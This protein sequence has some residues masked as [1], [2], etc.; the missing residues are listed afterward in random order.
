[1]ARKFSFFNILKKL[2]IVKIAYFSGYQILTNFIPVFY[3]TLL[4][5]YLLPMDL[6]LSGV[7]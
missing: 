2:S 4:A 1:M 5:L 6:F 7:I 3:W